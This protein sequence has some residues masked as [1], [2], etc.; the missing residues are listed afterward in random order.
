MS[1][2]KAVSLIIICLFLPACM[3]STSIQ[4]QSTFQ[5]DD[6]T[7]PA[8]K[9]S[10]GSSIIPTQKNSQ[11]ALAEFG[12]KLL[13][14]QGSNHSHEDK[15]HE[16]VELFKEDPITALQ[17]QQNTALVYFK[18]K[19]N[20]GIK[21][22]YSILINTMEPVP[23]KWI[24]YD[25]S[26]ETPSLKAFA[27][28]LI[29]NS[30]KKKNLSDLINNNIELSITAQKIFIKNNELLDQA[31]LI[32]MLR[33]VDEYTYAPETT[34]KYKPV[35]TI[36]P[37]GH[38]DKINNVLFT[39]DGR[40]LITASND[41]T[42]RIWNMENG[43][44]QRVIRGHIGQGYEGMIYCAAL[45]TDNQWLAA[46]GAL[47]SPSERAI[48]LYDFPSGEM[49][50][51]LKG[52]WNTINALAFSPD[53]R[54]LA[55]GSSDNTVCIWDV[56]NKKKSRRL[57]GHAQQVYTLE[58]LD[59]QRIVSGSFDNTLI[60]WD[61]G[62]GRLL[63][64]LQGHTDKVTALAV[65]P[66]GK[67]IASGSFD[68]TIR[69]WDGENGRLIKILAIQNRTVWSLSFSPDGRSLV[70]GIGGG[71]AE[72]WFEN[73]VYEV[74]S[75]R[76]L[77]TFDQHKNS[78]FAAAF[79]PDGRLAATGG[80]DNFEI[81]LW[82]PDSG[83]IL[84]TLVGK[85]EMVWSVGFSRDGGRIGWGHLFTQLSPVDMGPLQ[86]QF[87][88]GD[89]GIP[90]NA[91]YEGAINDQGDFIRAVTSRGGI[92]L[93]VRK[94]GAFGFS[95]SVL[96]VVRQGRVAASIER[97]VANGLRHWS[98]SLTPDNRYLVSGGN[99]GNLTL[100]RTSDGQK[101]FDFVGHTGQVWA[102][103]VS[104]D[105]KR[106]VSGSSDQTVRVWNLETGKNIISLFVGSDDEWVA[107][108][109]DGYYISSPGG[110]DYIGWHIN[111]GP[112]K[113]ADFYTARQFERILYRP[114]YV[115]ACIKHGGDRNKARREIGGDFFDIA[116]LQTIAPPQIKI[117]A[118]YS[119][120][121]SQAKIKI[122][123]NKRSLP[124][125]D[126]GVFVN[127]IP[128]TPSEERVLDGEE[129][130]IFNREIKI[131][132]F[133]RKNSIR[134][135]VLNGKSM[136]VE[137]AFI[138]RDGE[139]RTTKAG[140]LYLLAIGVN[141]FPEVPGAD[142][143]YA[144]QDADSLAEFFKNK[145]NTYFRNIHTHVLSDH[146][147]RLPTRKNILDALDFLKKAQAHD[148]SI[149]F[150][151]SHGLSDKAGDYYFVPRDALKK[152]VLSAA[153]GARGVKIA[154]TDF[155]EESSEKPFS[156][157]SWEVLFDALRRAAGRRLLI[158]D[159]CQANSVQGTL[160]IHSL[161]KRSAS[162]YFSLLAASKG[163][164]ESQEYEAG[165][166]GLFTYAL[167]QG[168]GGKGD[169]DKN[170]LVTLDELFSFTQS[171]VE[172]NREWRN[173]PQTP[174]MQTL[175]SLRD[176]VLTAP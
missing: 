144:A 43:G 164:E 11:T 8:P 21:A 165:Q 127:G 13:K 12:E 170:G 110:D 114:E 147:G 138:K 3:A 137:K 125:I 174:Q 169:Q 53:G 162:A 64:R 27:K 65:S 45:S 1:I 157:L 54:W 20:Q 87:Y 52:H 112:N 17:F 159:T 85:G 63:Y 42:I 123:V 152:D 29:E 98:F 142:L 30:G 32:S 49:A 62:Q 14:I 129:Q 15:A 102:V 116:D 79:S 68:K 37:G 36:D 55:S 47:G 40:Y 71:D 173:K 46:A 105:G 44:I 86:K 77:T 135:E 66:D 146:T 99:S 50:G 89:G 160:D 120:N 151:A 59:E 33:K 67:T 35:L 106:L 122:S 161:K 94:G 109:P 61:A 113:N 175:D 115:R 76:L 72:G 108:T 57:T 74:P 126:Y 136:G 83:K 118:P 133:G 25:P 111:N 153:T 39:K 167:L 88:L 78:V 156:L 119:V 101:I 84:Q 82:R 38:K 100:H 124:M 34:H 117:K 155:G 132:L 143:K 4:K 24:K 128:V 31:L 95:N 154:K 131:P 73:R 166:H 48:R 172:N 139:L 141:R 22:L 97:G 140:D 134:V 91:T 58:W 145:G 158:V 168:L 70:S 5:W 148:T 93:R 121:D 41:K 96:E 149:L 107:W 92:S 56:H 103:A 19:D 60:I 6:Q 2:H 171:F 10:T 80:G 75:G 90:S 16:L 26:A 18:D 23:I 81:H 7:E 69:L 9:K 51:N 150:L 163:S 104:P 176:M 130:N 28:G